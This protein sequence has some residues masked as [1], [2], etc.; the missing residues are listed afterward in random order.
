MRY[1]DP[2]DSCESSVDMNA[3]NLPQE[4]GNEHHVCV[5]CGHANNGILNSQYS[6]ATTH[7]DVTI[8]PLRPAGANALIKAGSARQR[9][10]HTLNLGEV[11]V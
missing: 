2:K 10:Q 1:D 4:T 8:M 3:A 7:S 5:H 6:V 9:Q 11:S